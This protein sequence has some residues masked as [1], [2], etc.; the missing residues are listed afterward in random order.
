MTGHLYELTEAGPGVF[1]MDEVDS[2]VLTR[3]TREYVVMLVAK[4]A[5]VEVVGVG[6]V[7]EV[8]MAEESVCVNRPTR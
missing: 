5:E 1:L 8:V 4:D 2:L 6:N 3:V 7:Y